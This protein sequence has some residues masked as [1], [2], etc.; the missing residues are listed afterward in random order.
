MAARA[1]A[2]AKRTL[3]FHRV[4]GM[5]GAANTLAA[6]ALRSGWGPVTMSPSGAPSGNVVID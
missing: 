6:D 5:R 4:T 3:R 1:A 2:P